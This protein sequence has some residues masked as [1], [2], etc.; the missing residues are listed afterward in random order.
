MIQ[1]D[2][3]FELSLQDGVVV[4]MDK[5]GGSGGVGEGEAAAAAAA[6]AEAAGKPAVLRYGKSPM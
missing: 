6:A 3:L 4:P 5:S 2:T 1:E